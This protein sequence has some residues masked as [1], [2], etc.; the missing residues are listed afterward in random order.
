MTD[1]LFDPAQLASPSPKLAWLER[2]G[3]TTYRTENGRWRCELS[4]L[5]GAEDDTEE[6]AILKFCEATKLRHYSLE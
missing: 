4:V 5:A 3:I 2:H 6:G 1:E